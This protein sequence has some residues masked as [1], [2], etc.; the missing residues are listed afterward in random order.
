MNIFFLD[1]NPKK[2]AEYMTDKHVVKMILESAQLLCTAHRVLDGR[3]KKTVNIASNR[4]KTDYVFFDEREKE[5]YKATHINHP[6]SKWVR[7][8]RNN[9]YWL[10][11]HFVALLKEY[12]FRYGKQHKCSKLV[13][14]LMVSPK[15]IKK[16]LSNL[17]TTTPPNAMDEVFII[18]DNP[19][20]NYRNY[21]KQGKKHLHK[22][23]KRERPEWI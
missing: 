9:Y 15:N 21:Y 20:M 23:T 11:E 7:E 4:T 2:A 1:K 13:N 8:D 6:S 10:F 12:S 22:W 16:D 5:L 17:E 14:M 18:S 19:I 3:V